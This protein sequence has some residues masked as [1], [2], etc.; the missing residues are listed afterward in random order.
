MNKWPI[1]ILSNSFTIFFNLRCKL[2]LLSV[3]GPLVLGPLFIEFVSL[4]L[5][6]RIGGTEDGG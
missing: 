1:F 2:I 6:S 3:L 4:G 5:F